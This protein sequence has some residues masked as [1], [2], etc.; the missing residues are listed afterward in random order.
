MSFI[1]RI[2][3]VDIGNWHDFLRSSLNGRLGRCSADYSAKAAMIRS[4]F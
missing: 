3:S 4:N 1:V 2:Y